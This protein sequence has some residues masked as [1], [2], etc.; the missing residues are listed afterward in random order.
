M[1][2]W[3][4]AVAVLLV[5]APSWADEWVAYKSKAGGVAVTFP[6]NPTEQTQEANGNM[7]HM[8][9]YSSVSGD[10]KFALLWTDLGPNAPK[11]S[12]KQMFDEAQGPFAQRAKIV[13]AKDTTYRGLP[14]RE[15]D[16]LSSDNKE[17]V[18]LRMVIKTS[19]VF[20]V[21]ATVVV[22]AD[23]KKFI[24]SLRID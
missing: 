16:L 2:A 8:A 1:R 23:A 4:I 6:G 9:A 18:K 5:S 7:L 3:V 12:T 24:D 21:A 11:K 10:V 15:L 20:L 19:R 22:P 17:A 13:S 14:A